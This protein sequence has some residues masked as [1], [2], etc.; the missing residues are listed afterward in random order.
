MIIYFD[1]RVTVFK[2]LTEFLMPKN[3]HGRLLGSRQRQPT[4]IDLSETSFAYSSTAEKSNVISYYY[5]LQAIT[6]LTK[7]PSQTKLTWHILRGYSTPVNLTGI[8]VHILPRFSLFALYV[9]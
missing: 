9:Q 6:R 5:I 2:I 8:D 1:T 4:N 7:S 3:K